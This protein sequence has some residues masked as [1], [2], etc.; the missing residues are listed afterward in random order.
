MNINLPNILSNIVNLFRNLFPS[1]GKI[2]T[3]YSIVTGLSFL[4]LFIL[5]KCTEKEVV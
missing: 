5:K 1:C 4:L 3:I 2:L